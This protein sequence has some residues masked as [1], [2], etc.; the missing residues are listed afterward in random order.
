MNSVRLLLIDDHQV[1]RQGLRSMLE[2]DPEFQVVGEGASAR[3]A[4]SLVQSLQPDVVLLD[5]Q[6]PGGGGADLCLHLIQACPT[7]RVVVLT[8]FLNQSLVEACLR[9]GARG[10]LLKETEN[11]HLKERL[12]AV[13]AGNTV[14]DARVA[15]L[16]TEYLCAHE[17]SPGVL[18]PREMEVMVL[19]AQGLSNREIGDKLFVSENTVKGHVK[20]ILAKLNVQNRVAAVVKAREQNLI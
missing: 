18:T 9:A 14:V 7:V 19:M 17:A 13:M 1:V 6:L 16:L 11:L 2:S 15:N 5:L 10:Y 20:E 12:R 8:A 4:L 3:D